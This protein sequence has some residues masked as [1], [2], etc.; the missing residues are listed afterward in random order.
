LENGSDPDLNARRTPKPL[1]VLLNVKQLTTIIAPKSLSK[2]KYAYILQFYSK[3]I[4]SPLPLSKLSVIF[5][6]KFN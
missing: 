4:I 3:I 6:N 2:I 5:S 1:R